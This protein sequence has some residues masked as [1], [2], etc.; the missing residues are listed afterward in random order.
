[1]VFRVY[2]AEPTVSC[3]AFVMLLSLVASRLEQ[4]FW[5]LHAGELLLS[6]AD[7]RVNPLII[8]IGASKA[9]WMGLHCPPPYPPV[10]SQAMHLAS[11]EK[12]D[13]F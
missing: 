7:W 8:V 10:L 5:S 9:T 3:V 2:R 13:T 1:M 6:L 11:T 12:Q 4:I